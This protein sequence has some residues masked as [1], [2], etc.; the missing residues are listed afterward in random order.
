MRTP[1]REPALLIVT[2]ASGAGKT[3]LVRA[4]DAQR[5]PGVRC[6]HFDDIGVPSPDE[7]E[8]VHGGGAQWQAAATEAWIQRLARNDDGAAVAV[9]D[10]QVR[11]GM[12]LAALARHSVR[13]ARV[14]LVDCDYAERNARLRGPRAQPELA[15]AEMDRWAAYLRGQADALELPVIDTTGQGI[16]EAATSLGVHVDECR[17][18]A[19]HLHPSAFSSNY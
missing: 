17:A 8:R 4:L 5:R 18:A 2:G 15:T 19:V 14:V 3:T 1:S 10:A 16:D 13:R 11:P 6:Y 9:L 12:V 7:M